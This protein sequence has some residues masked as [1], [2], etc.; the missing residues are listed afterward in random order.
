VELE[1][2]EGAVSSDAEV[3]RMAIHNLRHM[4]GILPMCQ[5]MATE[6]QQLT[7]YDRVMIYRFDEDQHGEVISEAMGREL[8]DRYL[9]RHFP[10]GD[11][12]V[13]ARRLYLRQLCRLLVDIEYTPVP[14]VPPAPADERLDLS[15]AALRSMSP[16]HCDY[17]RNM[18]VRGTLTLSI[19]IEDRLWGLVAC[20]HYGEPRYIDRPTRELAALLTEAFTWSLHSSL[21]AERHIALAAAVESNRQILEGYEV[22]EDFHEQLVQDMPGLLERFEAD[23]IAYLGPDEPVVVGTAVPMPV[24]RILGR[25]LAT[26]GLDDIL[27]TDRLPQ[28]VPGLGH[29]EGPGCGCIALPIDQE[30]QHH[31]VILANERVRQIQKGPSHGPVIVTDGQARLRPMA[32]FAVHDEL[33]RQRSRPWS[34]RDVETA[35]LL[36]RGLNDARHRTNRRLAARNR[37]L[38]AASEAKDA[39]LAV[40]SHELRNPLNAMVGWAALL[41][42]GK[43]TD[44]KLPKAYDAL[45]QNARA[46]QRLIDDLLDVSSI[47]NGKVDL[48]IDVLDP[49]ELLHTAVEVMQGR[50]DDRGIRLQTE[51][52]THNP[53]RG[54]RERVIQILW[55][56]LS[57][58]AKYTQTGGR[59]R[60]SVFAE[61]STVVFEVEDNGVGI[62]DEAI[63]LLFERFLQVRQKGGMQGLGLGLSIVKGLADLHHATVDVESGGLG[64][65]SIF[66][67][68]FPAP[69]TLNTTPPNPSTALQVHLQ[70]R[71]LV[72]VDDQP[73]A[74]MLLEILLS[75]A[76]A[77]V[78]AFVDPNEALAF[79][80]TYEGRLDLL[81][82]DVNMAP[83][84]GYELARQVHDIDRWNTLP[85]LAVT[86]YARSNDRVKAYRAGFTAH[87]AKPIDTDELL[88]MV[89][90]M[91]RPHGA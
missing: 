16:I 46:Q 17:L 29:H 37:E 82:S 63:P 61:D 14:L 45:H 52:R 84:D 81:I 49:A 47:A 65:G 62:S 18:G 34:V 23:T 72:V 67:V 21:T 3:F 44:D 71:R 1:P 13:Q 50:F 69:I 54:D 55:N 66:R 42:Q 85:M 39:F 87:I 59:V 77:T 26:L 90:T 68:R 31:L 74:V 53:I 30:G 10:E 15:L 2:F 12:P 41:Q 5:Q 24:L 43:V 91:G 25:H 76:G 86:A 6:I 58:A 80:K 22:A 32:S 70:D 36:L 79:M 56:L 11:I 28:V 35:R 51:V 60:I 19:R 27:V 75:D 7:G 8:P 33:V 9:H 89:G 88:A 4:S 64:H 40:L 48:R 20:H 73:D 78:H 38:K 57:N 83:I